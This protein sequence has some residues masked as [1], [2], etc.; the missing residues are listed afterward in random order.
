MQLAHFNALFVDTFAPKS[1]PGKIK[2][3][4]SI[5]KTITGKEDVV[6]LRSQRLRVRVPPGVQEN[7][8]RR[9]FTSTR[10]FC[11]LMKFLCSQLS[12]KD[13][14]RLQPLFHYHQ[15]RSN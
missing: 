11:P 4:L 8:K 12:Y 14:R 5:I 7:I 3:A 6:G 1:H 9:G 2:K 13:K 15:Y 10:S